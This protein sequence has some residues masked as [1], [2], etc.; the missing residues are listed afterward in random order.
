MSLISVRNKNL[1]FFFSKSKNVP[2]K[3]VLI[4]GG[5]SY[6]ITS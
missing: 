2:Y 6:R 3:D 4:V 1:E 5:Y